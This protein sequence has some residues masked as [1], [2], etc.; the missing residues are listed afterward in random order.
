MLSHLADLRCDLMRYFPQLGIDPFEVLDGPTFFDLAERV[1]AYGGV[2]TARIREI[3]EQH[4]PLPTVESRRAR[5]GGAKV[6]ELAA[7]QAMDPD[8]IDRRHASG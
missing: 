2:M 3:A 4:D 8:L 1:A 6:V 5:A 7:L